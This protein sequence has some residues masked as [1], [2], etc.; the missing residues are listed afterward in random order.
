MKHVLIIAFM[1]ALLSCSKSSS[2]EAFKSTHTNAPE[3]VGQQFPEY[4]QLAPGTKWVVDGNRIIVHIVFETINDECSMAY[5][6]FKKD[7][8]LVNVNYE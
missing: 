8:T 2:I 4:K 1:I 5:G 7:G 3:L 6:V